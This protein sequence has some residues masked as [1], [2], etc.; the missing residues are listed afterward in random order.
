MFLQMRSAIGLNKGSCKKFKH[1]DAAW[2]EYLQQW[3]YMMILMI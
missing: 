2:L 1:S 3:Q